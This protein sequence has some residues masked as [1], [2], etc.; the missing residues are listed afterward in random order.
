MPYLCAGFPAE[1]ETLP[2][3]EALAAA[4]AD[5]IELGIPFS[6][7]LMDGPVIQDAS[8]K[9]LERGATPV[10]VLAEAAKADIGIP[11]VAMT[12]MD[13]I[14]PEGTGSSQNFGSKPWPDGKRHRISKRP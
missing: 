9:A 5:A 6:D 7:P 4:G 14:S 10:S 3:L 2:L 12:S 11:M 8:V 13:G 1:V